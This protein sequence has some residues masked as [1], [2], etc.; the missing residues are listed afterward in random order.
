[1]KDKKGLSAVVTTV[2]IILLVLVAIGVVWM[3]VKDMIGGG[4]GQAALKAKCLA[5]EVKLAQA[6]CNPVTG[7]SCPVTLERV[8]GSD[9]IAGV[10]LVFSNDLGSITVR[11]ED[12][13]S[14]TALAG[15]IDIGARKTVVVSPGLASISD[16]KAM[17]YFLDDKGSEQFCEVPSERAVEGCPVV[18]ADCTVDEDC[19]DDLVCTNSK[20]AAA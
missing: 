17:V 8:S 9:E 19:C 3:V 11:S 5:N 2:V 12:S 13:G 6:I 10:A 16:V 7:L 20:C 1:M 18:D 15:N 4:T 14:G